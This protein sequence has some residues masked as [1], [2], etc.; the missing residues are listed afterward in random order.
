MRAMLGIPAGGAPIR[1]A[2]RSSDAAFRLPEH[3]M[4]SPAIAAIPATPTTQ[5]GSEARE[6]R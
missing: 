3:H 4:N 6:G 1:R 5:T 2:N